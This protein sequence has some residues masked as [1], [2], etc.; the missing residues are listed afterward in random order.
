MAKT[1][2]GEVSKLTDQD[3]KDLAKLQRE[4]CNEVNKGV[5]SFVTCGNKLREIRS[6]QLYSDEYPD[7][8]DYVKYEIPFERTWVYA[9]MKSSACFDAIMDMSDNGQ[10]LFPNTGEAYIELSRSVVFDDEENT[11]DT[12]PMQPV[13]NRAVEI[14]VLASQDDAG[15]EISKPVLSKSHIAKARKEL[16]GDATEERAAGPE[17]PEEGARRRLAKIFDGLVKDMQMLPDV[18]TD[19]NVRAAGKLVKIFEEAQ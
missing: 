8:W 10:P 17:T 12:D 5:R 1:T 16:A 3:R 13:Y 4:I 19:A 2:K 14:A 11:Y 7:F 6:R 9:S 15:E 18:F